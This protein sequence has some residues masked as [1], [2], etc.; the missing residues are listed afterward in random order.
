MNEIIKCVSDKKNTW[1]FGSGD[2]TEIITKIKLDLKNEDSITISTDKESTL[3][4]QIARA[5]KS[6]ETT[7]VYFDDYTADEEMITDLGITAKHF[8][9]RFNL[10]FDHNVQIIGYSTILPSWIT[11]DYFEIIKV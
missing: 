9:N 11:K 4:K 8:V 3:Y 6:R 1:L 10:Y 7:V 5:I 2:K